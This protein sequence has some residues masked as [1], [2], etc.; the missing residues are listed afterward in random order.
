M[1]RSCNSPDLSPVQPALF[2]QESNPPTDPNTYRDQIERAYVALYQKRLGSDD[3]TT[4]T[5][6]MVLGRLVRVL[7]PNRWELSPLAGLIYERERIRQ[8]HESLMQPEQFTTLDRLFEGA[9][10][11][12]TTNPA[13]RAYFERMQRQEQQGTRR[14]R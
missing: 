12:Y 13:E 5:E 10:R 8:S 9:I 1:R 6:E 3:L 7:M 14:S 4:S 11:V 2:R